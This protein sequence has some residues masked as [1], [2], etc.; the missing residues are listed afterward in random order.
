MRNPESK[1]QSMKFNVNERLLNE[2]NWIW[3]KCEVNGIFFSLIYFI[4]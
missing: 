3:L 1:I 2:T 4:A